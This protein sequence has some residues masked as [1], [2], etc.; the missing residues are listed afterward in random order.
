VVFEVLEYH[1]RGLILVFK[2]LPLYS[3]SSN[4]VFEDLECGILGL[5]L[6]LKAFKAMNH[7]VGQGI[8]FGFRV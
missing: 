2:A 1:I 4:V 7:H 6:V 3:R 5:A 8:V